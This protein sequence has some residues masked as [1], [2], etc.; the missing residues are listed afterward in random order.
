MGKLP[1]MTGAFIFLG[2]LCAF[3]GWAVIESVLWVLSH[4]SIGWTW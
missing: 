4:I 2:F 1:D 3:A